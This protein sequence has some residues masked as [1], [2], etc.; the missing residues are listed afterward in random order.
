MSD[1][2]MQDWLAAVTDAIIAEE[3]DFEAF[4]DAYAGPRGDAQRLMGLIRRLKGTLVRVKPAPRFSRRLK[5]D[6]LDQPERNLVWRIRRLPA[7][8]QMAA[9]VT[10][11]AGFSLVIRRRLWPSSE[12]ELAGELTQ[13]QTEEIATL[14]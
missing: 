2:H 7:R 4:I 14:S 10:L 6:L 12:K 8:V 5:Q 13:A 11:V 1:V 9:L 3:E